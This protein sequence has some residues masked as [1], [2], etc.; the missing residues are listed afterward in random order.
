[1]NEETSEV[2]LSDAG[3]AAKEY[4]LA[5][6]DKAATSNSCLDGDRDSRSSESVW[7]PGSGPPSSPDLSCGSWVFSSFST[8]PFC[9]SSCSVVEE[10]KVLDFLK[11]GESSVVPELLPHQVIT[12]GGGNPLHDVV[13]FKYVI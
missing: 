2:G 3:P 13:T 5:G 6:S 9:N 10:E 11:L 7:A 8:R 1:M 4:E 12:N